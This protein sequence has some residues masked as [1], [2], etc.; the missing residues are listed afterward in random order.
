MHQTSFFFLRTAVASHGLLWFLTNFKIFFYLCKKNAIGIF[1]GIVLALQIVWGCKVI[2]S[3]GDMCVQVIRLGLIKSEK[4]EKKR[5]ETATLEKNKCIECGLLVYTRADSA[6]SR[7]E[8]WM[9]SISSDRQGESFLMM[10]P[11]GPFYPGLAH[12]ILK[13]TFNLNTH[14]C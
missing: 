11:L 2:Y 7:S 9:N 13:H 12:L 14:R 3:L 4:V 6:R 10:P 5:K 1:I 8:R